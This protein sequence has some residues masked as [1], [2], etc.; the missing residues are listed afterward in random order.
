MIKKKKTSKRDRFG[1]GI[2]DFEFVSDFD[3]RVSDFGERVQGSR[4]NS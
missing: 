3:I 4:E 2:S 1:F